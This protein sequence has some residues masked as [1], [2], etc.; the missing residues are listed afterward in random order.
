MITN[1]YEDID[2]FVKSNTIYFQEYVLH[3]WVHYLLIGTDYSIRYS[4]G[5]GIGFAKTKDIIDFHYE[6]ANSLKFSKLAD[7]IDDFPIHIK[8][9]FL[10]NLDLCR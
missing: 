3:G 5:S 2:D 8:K 4:N 1:K 6:L 9:L 7:V 10:F